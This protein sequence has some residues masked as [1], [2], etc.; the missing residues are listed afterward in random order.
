MENNRTHCLVIFLIHYERH[1]KSCSFLSFKRTS[2]IYVSCGFVIG[3]NA[4]RQLLWLSAH[5]W[6]LLAFIWPWNSLSVCPRGLSA[7]TNEVEDEDPLP[8]L[9]LI[10]SSVALLLSCP[11]DWRIS[12]FFSGD[13]RPTPPMICPPSNILTSLSLW[14]ELGGILV[15]IGGSWP[16]AY[17]LFF[18][19]EKEKADGIESEC[20][21]SSVKPTNNMVL[22]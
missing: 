13:T 11:R 12:D 19:L 22:W 5:L 18:R 10:I 2:V 1:K 14:G 17:F 21:Y 7:K 15:P 20:M 4:T 9:L 6:A 16:S 8:L 3:C